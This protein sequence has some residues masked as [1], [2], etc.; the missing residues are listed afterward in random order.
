MFIALRRG[1]PGAG[2]GGGLAR[3]GVVTIGDCAIGATYFWVAACGD[4]VRCMGDG[5]EWGGKCGRKRRTYA[6]D[7]VGGRAVN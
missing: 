5:G 3:L 1:L 2:G 7:A 4:A 6:G